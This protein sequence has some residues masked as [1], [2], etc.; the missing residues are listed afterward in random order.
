MTSCG[1]SSAYG[2]SL[3]LKT[4]DFSIYGVNTFDAR[5]DIPL[6]EERGMSERLLCRLFKRPQD[7]VATGH[8]GVERCLSSLLP[9]ERSLDLF[10]PDVA[11]LHHVAEAQAARILGRLLV[12]EFLQR[13]LQRRVFLVEAVLH[14]LF[15]G[16]LGDRQIAG[17]L[18]QL[19]LAVGVGK[20]SDELGDALV[21]F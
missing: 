4:A 19:G 9:C 5:R 13:R 3:L 21:L 14:G 8:R 17:F 18:M 12:G 10:G 7:G 6:S 11:H 15:V 16:R 1:T 20:E 2:S